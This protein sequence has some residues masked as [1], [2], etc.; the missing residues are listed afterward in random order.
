MAELR[1]AKKNY[2]E[3]GAELKL[4]LKQNL[5]LA[6]ALPEFFRTRMTVAGAVGG[7]KRHLEGRDEGFL[8]LMRCRVYERSGH[9]YLKL[10]K[11]A[12]CE[13]SDLREQVHRRGLEATL[14]A[15]AGEGVY[16]TADEFKG[17]KEVRRGRQVF[18]V[19]P[20]DFQNSSSIASPGLATRSSGTNNA[21]IRT[22]LPLDR[23]AVRALEAAVFFSAHGL[24]D[25]SH[26]V[27][28]A[29]LPAA[30]GVTNLLVNAKLG[31]ATDRWFARKVPVGSAMGQWY[32]YLSTY[33]IV[34][35]GKWYGPGFPRPEFVD[36]NDLG[37]IPRWVSDQRL[38]GRS[39]C[40]KAA[41]SN[42]TRIAQAAQAMGISL[43]GAK[44]IVSGEPFTESKRDVI[45]RAGASA[46]VRYSYSGGGTVGNGCGN[47]VYIDE[48][49]INKHVFAVVAH[50]A[51]S[52]RDGRPVRPLLFTTLLGVNP[53]L[54]LNVENGDYGSLEDRDCGCAL[55]QAGLTQHLHGIRSYEKFTS[56]GMNYFYGDLYEI[57]EKTL[58]A[59]FG[60]GP[61]DYQFVEEEDERGQTRLTLRV[62]P[63]VS[64]HDE[65][66]LLRRLQEELAKGSRG[67]EFQAKVWQ[68]AGTLRIRREAPHSS[69]RG[70]IL[71]LHVVPRR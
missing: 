58:P 14:E 42:A 34:L 24:F 57:F 20:G 39:C 7:I 68:D 49:H 13:F 12:G 61:G 21:P 19:S 11:I 51:N 53:R 43:E 23:I 45:H 40:V 17:K 52:D 5:R 32:Q 47:P 56:E 2:R 63:R 64:I 25:R 22:V 44:F 65:S 35:A 3:L 41:A 18:R 54:L 27:Y 8:E 67:N 66:G 9:P 16:L 15:L 70:K 46:T 26:A 37:R 71:P 1:L 6:G 31:I 36:A 60:G 33:L 29:I 28:D 30:G 69:A 48:I 55:G 10:L 38:R 59:E 4:G 62:H 50:P